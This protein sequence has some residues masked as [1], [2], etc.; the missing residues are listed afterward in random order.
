VSV[1]GFRHVDVDPFDLVGRHLVL[2]AQAQRG[3]DGSVQQAHRGIRLHGDP[4]GFPEGAEARV[5]QA[6]VR[7]VALAERGQPTAV[8]ALE[9][10]LD[11][12]VA[13]GGERR[14]GQAVTGGEAVLHALDH[15][16]ELR[17]HQATGLGRG[18][19]KS[20][21]EP[22]GVEPVEGSRGRGGRQGAEDHARMPASGDHLQAAERLAN[23]R[24]RLIAEDRA[25][26]ETSPGH[27]THV[28]GSRQHSGDDQRVAVERGERVVV[29]EFE[30]LDETGIEHR[31][32]WGAGRAPAP[33]DQ[34]GTPGAVEGCDT[35]HAL[36]GDR[37]LGAH[38]RAGDAVEQQVLCVLAYGGGNVVQRGVGEPG[39]EPARGPIRVGGGAGGLPGHVD[40]EFSGNCHL[41]SPLPL[42]SADRSE[43][44]VPGSTRPHSSG[45]T[46]RHSYS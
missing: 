7:M 33:A 35:F 36:A 44:D 43:G 19:P 32:R 27:P 41:I 26:Q 6:R 10:A 9:D 25:Q 31:G 29:V 23:P 5:N 34:R 18:D 21:L 4:V 39:G 3:V 8:L 14:G 15:R 45:P 42:R 28:R 13:G 40:V 12:D 11:A 16:L 2:G 46:R 30:P 1:G 22:G 38:Q 24:S 37:E 20:V 17:R